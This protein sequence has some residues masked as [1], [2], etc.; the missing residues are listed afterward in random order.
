MNDRDGLV[1]DIIQS[2]A[3]AATKTLVDRAKTKD[4]W[5]DGPMVKWIWIVQHELL[6]R[7]S[8]RRG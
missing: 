6:R 2:R 5:P 1:M 4:D 3:Y 7:K 8:E